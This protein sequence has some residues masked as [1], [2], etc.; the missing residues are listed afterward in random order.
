MITL[1]P[2]LAEAAPPADVGHRDH[3]DAGLGR[4]GVDD[5]LLGGEH[6]QAPADVGHRDHVDAGL[7]RGGVDDVL[8]GGEHHQARLD[9]ALG[10]GEVA[11]LV[12]AARDLEI[13]EAILDLVAR[14]QLLLELGDALDCLRQL[15]LD[16]ADRA[17]QAGQVRSV[18]DQLAVEHGRNLVDAVGEQEAAIK[19]RDL[20]VRERDE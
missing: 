15:Q 13:D 19:H 18:V 7:G 11:A 17:L 6:H 9:V 8:L 2:V 20:G 4:G 14:D 3:V 16:L 12:G 5:V 1:M 10:K